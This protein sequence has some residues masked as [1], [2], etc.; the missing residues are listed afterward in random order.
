[1]KGFIAGTHDVGALNGP[2]ATALRGVTQPCQDAGTNRDLRMPDTMTH[3]THLPRWLM[4]AWAHSVGLYAIGFRA[5]GARASRPGRPAYHAMAA[6]P[7]WPG[8]RAVGAYMHSVVPTGDFAAAPGAAVR[9]G[10]MRASREHARARGGGVSPAV[11]HTQHT[12][13]HT[14]TRRPR[15]SHLCVDSCRVQAVAG[16]PP[17]V[18]PAGAPWT[19]VRAPGDDLKGTPW[20]ARNR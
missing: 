14:H 17:G 9:R 11:G 2:V 10:S 5:L 18:I 12:H 20:I 16:V 13:T 15:T 1:M 4:C 7:N 8:R 6:P 19:R 3:N